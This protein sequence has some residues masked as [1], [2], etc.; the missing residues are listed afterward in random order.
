MDDIL[1]ITPPDKIFNQ[2]RSSLLVYPTEAVRKSVEHWLEHLAEPQNVYI[3]NQHSDHD[4]DWLLSVAKFA[5]TT[6]L[7]IDNCDPVIEPLCSYLVSL[8]QTYWTTQYESVYSYLSP[9]RF[10]DANAIQYI[11]GDKIEETHT[12]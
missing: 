1:V 9:N 8:P 11:L 10:W 4:V 2:N 3:Y 7:D 12:Q 5:D 6:I